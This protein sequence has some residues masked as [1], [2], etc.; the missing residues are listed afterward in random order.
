M[1]HVIGFSKQRTL[2]LA[3][4]A[5]LLFSVCA[6]EPKEEKKPKKSG[7]AALSALTV[8]GVKAASIPSA[9]TSAVW[10]D[11][12]F[13]DL[14]AKYTQKIEYDDEAA[15]ASAAIKATAVSKAKVEYAVTDNDSARPDLFIGTGQPASFYIDNYLY[16]KVISENGENINYYR[17]FVTLSDKTR[18]KT[19][20]T[21]IAL[22]KDALTVT[23]FA[24]EKLKFTVTP[25]NGSRRVTWSSGSPDVVSVSDD[26]T[27]KALKFTS[28]GD[29]TDS[30]EA[31]GAAVITVTSA[32][33]LQDSIN[34]TA[35]M[36]GQTDILTLPPMKDQFGDY[37][38]MGN[39]ASNFVV[40]LAV[41]A[42]GKINDARLLRHYNILT[43]ENY[44]KPSYLSSGRDAA[45]GEISYNFTV[46]SNP[47]RLPVDNF[48]DSA[49]ASGFLIHGHTLLWHSQNAQW[50]NALMTDDTLTKEDAIAIMRKYI[51]D[52]V[53][54]YKGK[55]YSWDILNEAFSD[56]VGAVSDW[57]KSIRTG[58]AGTGNPWFVKIGSD[59]VYEGYLA[60]RLADPKAILYYNDYNTDQVGKATMIRNMVRD[61]NEKY[62]LEYDT[63]RPLIEGIGMQEHHNTNISAAAIKATLELFKPLGVRVSVSELDVLSQPYGDFEGSTAPSNNGKLNAA[64]L[65][66]QYFKLYIEYSDIIER[67][68]LWGVYDR[69]SWRAS[70]LPL[71][72]EGDDPASY[73][74]TACF[75][76]PAY[77][78]IIEAL[79]D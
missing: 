61:V 37:F 16:I 34:I 14:N 15:F 73:I 43:A 63:S 52:V 51:T 20:A 71:L 38:M 25:P 8:G 41:A 13:G 30:A 46:S 11:V 55:I 31:S 40:A 35:T 7:A 60:A 33:G 62:M 17:F 45:T 44:M 72:F 42:D 70:G 36:A 67:V 64:N 28:G 65:Y 18:D 66:G 3:V 27:I 49:L 9:I 58:D 68:T 59:F 26:G 53:K 47:N 29:S 32:N 76:K 2:L 21:S 48:V 75:A 69:Q 1:L 4:A 10:N 54:R 39:I 79:E 6:G 19:P 74:P 50:M 78:K 5:V 12:V 77:Y 57:K 56:G 23:L 24:K 22:E